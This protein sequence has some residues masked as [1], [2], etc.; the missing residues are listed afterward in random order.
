[1]KKFSKFDEVLT[2]TSAEP[3]DDGCKNMFYVLIASTVICGL[4]GLRNS[5]L[6]SGCL[7]GVLFGYAFVE[8]RMTFAGTHRFP[9][10][11]FA[12]PNVYEND[13]MLNQQLPQIFSNTEM[14]V[15]KQQKKDRYVLKYKNFIYDVV[16]N[17]DNTFSIR[18][19][20][21]P[22]LFF[23]KRERGITW[24]KYRKLVKDMPMIAYAIQ[25]SGIQ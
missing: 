19:N 3:L 12:L 17:D 15:E 14:A 13:K 4:L 9:Y 24:I 6:L 1:M 7:V 16:V 2:L 11:K 10:V 23:M 21:P 20:V 5:D 8:I 22:Y 25:K 18:W